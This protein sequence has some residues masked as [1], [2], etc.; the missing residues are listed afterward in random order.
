M[1][2]SK[3]I[4]MD[5]HIHSHESKRTKSND[6][7]G[8]DL[9]YDRLIT[10]LEEEK[11]NLFSITD[12]NTINEEL[13]KE[14]HQ[15]RDQLIEKDMN[16]I[17]G[18]EIDFFDEEI[19][20]KTFHML[21]FFDTEDINKVAQLLAKVFEKEKNKDIDTSV[22]PISLKN[23][24]KEAFSIGI[25]NII[26]I[27]HF[28]QKDK[29]IPA[30]D[31]DKFVYTVFNAL[32]DSNNRNRL[33]KSIKVFKDF[34]YTDVPVVVFSDNHN[35]D[36][37]PCGKDK[38][39]DKLTSMSI[40]G[41]IKFPF[42]SV[43]AAF[44]D[45][46]TRISIQEAEVR[47]VYY[48]TKYI[49]SLKLDEDLIEFSP[50][51]NSIIGGFG[52]GKSFLLD[53]ILNGK[54]NVDSD[55][56]EDLVSKYQDFSI[57]FSDNTIRNS[58]NE[59]SGEV[60]IIRF[61]QYKDIYFKDKLYEEEKRLLENNLHI[62]FPSIE[63]I[64]KYSGSDIVM[65]F[66]KLDENM[67]NTSLITDIIN[68][69][70]L[71]R[72]NE[73]EYSFKTEEL[74]PIYMEPAYHESLLRQLTIESEREILHED[75]YTVSEKDTFRVTSD[76]ISNRNTQYGKWAGEIE[77]ILGVLNKDILRINEDVSNK[78][79][80]VSSNIKI[81]EDIKNDVLDYSRK[82]NEFRL[83]ALKFEENFSDGNYNV[84]KEHSKEKYIHSYKLSA[85]Y[86]ARN[87]KPNYIN[88][89]CKQ[90]HREDELFNSILSTLNSGDSFS[91][92]QTFEK[93]IKK[94]IDAYY[95]NFSRICYDIFDDESSILRKS[96]GEKANVIMNLIFDIIEENSKQDIPSIVILDQPEDNLD[97]KGI[98]NQVVNRIRALKYG[99]NLPQMICVTHNANISITADSENIIVASKENSKCFYNNSGIENDQ[100]IEEVCK[101]V[102]GGTLALKKR[103]IKFNIPMIKEIE[104]EG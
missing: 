104:M 43:K 76:L 66:K 27:P 49:K 26:T 103:G 62:T 57:T 36:I 64:E 65:A 48:K 39:K 11:V 73:K 92:N 85:R 31:I 34:N 8:V 61:N 14:L 22:R 17:I 4:K 95:S 55:K 90:P 16:F 10:A 29:G 28:N 47:D 30:N 6:Y 69:E 97:N 1:S 52:T 32:E 18:S 74:D 33:V 9:T 54:N 102:E 86:D 21:T 13:Y 3:W 42:N 60:K 24:F 91:Q 72:S 79:S 58:L 68:Y 25:G 7:D 35:I 93:R 5:L 88:E 99:N 80:L 12:H 44:Q 41:N 84:L 63:E 101:T 53:L 98:Q 87:D 82:L 77:S 20:D 40:L 81:W 50:Y 2:Y 45:V 89:I 83:Q 56:Y 100:F 19:H 94:Y 37:Y 15:K 70:A 23:F 51:Q 96:A 46:N 78:S 71:C 67:K 75:F 59:V 38:N